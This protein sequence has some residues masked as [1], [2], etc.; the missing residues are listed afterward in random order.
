MIRGKNPNIIILATLETAAFIMESFHL[1]LAVESLDIYFFL[2]I[3]IHI[4]FFIQLVPNFFFCVLFGLY[5]CE[6]DFYL[7]F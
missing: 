7:N 1:L 5:L 3:L 2:L 6:F 4:L